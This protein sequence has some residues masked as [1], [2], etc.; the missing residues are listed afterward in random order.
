LSSLNFKQV[1]VFT[2]K[3][4]W[5]NPVAVVIG[6]LLIAATVAQGQLFESDS[7][8]LGG[9]KMD[10]VVK[11]IERRDRFS[12]VEV[13]IKTVG[14]SVGSSFFLLC[15]LRQ[16]AIERGGYRYIV[17][18]EEQ[19]KRGQMLVG[20]LRSPAEGLAGLGKEFSAVTAKDAVIDLEQFA[21]ICAKMK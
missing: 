16:L 8:R 1:D 19:P 7:K 20:F 2:R 3:P 4:F 9:A 13:K 11:E 21:E 12:I 10:I 14:S 17:K 18:I 15:S 5:G 6:A